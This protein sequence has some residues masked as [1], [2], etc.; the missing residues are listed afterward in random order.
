MTESTKIA[1]VTG[2]N[3]GIGKEIARQLLAEGVTVL[4]GSRNAERGRLAAEELGARTVLLDVTDQS[5]VDSAAKLVERDFG[6]LDVL[7]NNAGINPERGA[8]PSELSAEVMRQVYDTNVFGVVRV[9][10]AFV[11]LLRRAEAPRIVNVSS[12]L[13]SLTYAADPDSP[14]AGVRLLAYNSSKTALNAVTVLYAND[15]REAGIKVNAIN[16]GYC[17][18]DLNGHQGHLD[19]SEGARVA[20]RLARIPGDGPSGEFH[21]AGAILPW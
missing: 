17:A 19:P 10:N 13:G 4:L 1:L 12:E 5:S 9:T 15:L 21:S 3:K 8:R 14:W 16:P 18:T 2:A 20:V 6:R 7:V 11:P